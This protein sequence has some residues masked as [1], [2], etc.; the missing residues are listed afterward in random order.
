MSEIQIN[1]ATTDDQ[2]QPAVAAEGE[3]FTVVWQSCDWNEWEGPSS[4]HDGWGCGIF[5]RRVLPYDMV[6]EEEYQVNDTIQ[7][8]Q[9][10]PDVANLGANL[11]MSWLS[12]AGE[13]LQVQLRVFDD[14]GN[15][16][17]PE[18][19]GNAIDHLQEW[20][21][22]LATSGDD[23][24]LVSWRG[25]GLE[26]TVSIIGQYFHW[27]QETKTLESVGDI[28]ELKTLGTMETMFPR[29]AALGNGGFVAVWSAAVSG[30]AYVESF[31]QVVNY[32][33]GPLLGDFVLNP[34]IGNGGA[35]SYPDVAGVGLAGDFIAVYEDNSIHAQY[36][37]GLAARLFSSDGTPL[38]NAKPLV[39]TGPSVSLPVVAHVSNGN[40]FIAWGTHFDADESPWLDAIHVMDLEADLSK[41]VTTTAN[42]HV[43]GYQKFV[44]VSVNQNTGHRMAV[45]ESCPWDQYNE[46]LDL[47][48]QDGDGCGI[49]ARI[50][51]N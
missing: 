19:P 28:L 44:R 23:Q 33:S 27:D 36:E 12:Y 22:F 6:L 20:K 35:Q 49:Y 14:V 11:V 39:I 5:A 26:G 41:N 25:I 30:D 45:W 40:H 38:G 3:S 9:V 17:S 16:Q 10:A 8:N 21:P 46:N 42:L 18:V 31:G 48:G 4:F 29:V 1:G 34:A 51:D 15:P 2:R 37:S 24:I 32:P 13:D 43:A 50:Y 7:Y 47:P